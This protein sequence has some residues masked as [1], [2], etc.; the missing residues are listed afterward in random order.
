MTSECPSTTLARDYVKMMS[1]KQE[2]CKKNWHVDKINR[3]L[4]KIYLFILVLKCPRLFFM[5]FLIAFGFSLNE[6]HRTTIRWYLNHGKNIYM[7]PAS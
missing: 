1:K 5:F 7:L 4:L 3:I 6:R 2:I